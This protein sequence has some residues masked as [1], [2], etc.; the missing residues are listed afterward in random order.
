[1]LSLKHHALYWGLSLST[2]PV[3][4]LR[5][6]LIRYGL[7]PDSVNDIHFPV[8]CLT[9]YLLI[10][11]TL[12]LQD[13]KLKEDTRDL[14]TTFSGNVIATNLDGPTEE[15]QIANES[16]SNHA[17]AN[18]NGIVNGNANGN[19]NGN[20]NANG[21]AARG[22]KGK[23]KFFRGAN[24]KPRELQLGEESDQNGNARLSNRNRMPQSPLAMPPDVSLRRLRKASMEKKKPTEHFLLVIASK[25]Y[26][27]LYF[28]SLALLCTRK[29]WVL[30]F[31]DSAENRCVMSAGRVLMTF[32]TLGT[33]EPIRRDWLWWPEVWFES[34][35]TTL[36]I[37]IRI[38]LLAPLIDIVETILYSISRRTHPEW[39]KEREELFQRPL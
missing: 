22:G 8:I 35:L 19:G 6:L 9:L 13:E 12:F 1:M 27:V 34:A 4:R 26:S 32:M 3:T 5:E 33:L 38:E 30:G 31:D 24:G 39:Y 36:D 18:G 21:K 7:F 2:I 20:G 16:N 17:N 37:W 29:D 15:Q 28:I 14:V 10:R 11:Y 25:H 23:K